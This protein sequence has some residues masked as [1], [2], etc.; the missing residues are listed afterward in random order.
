MAELDAVDLLLVAVLLDAAK[1]E[2]ALESLEDEDGNRRNWSDHVRV[3]ERRS[4][5]RTAR[6]CS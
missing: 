5:A 3:T 4:T 6:Q 1:H 2:Q